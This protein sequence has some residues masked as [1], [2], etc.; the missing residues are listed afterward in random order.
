VIPPY[1]SA[2]PLQRALEAFIAGDAPPVDGPQGRAR[3]RPRRGRKGRLVYDNCSPPL[4]CWIAGTTT[5]TSMS[6]LAWRNCFSG[7]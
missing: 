1:R 6:T 3:R 5:K 7:A 2:D 4:P